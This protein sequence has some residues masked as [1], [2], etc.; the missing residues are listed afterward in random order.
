MYLIYFL[1]QDIN[2]N[3]KAI[4]DVLDSNFQRHGN[5]QPSYCFLSCI[6]AARLQCNGGNATVA[7]QRFTD[8]YIRKK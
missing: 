2:V 8:G 5:V 7:M 3:I 6:D 1:K 4:V